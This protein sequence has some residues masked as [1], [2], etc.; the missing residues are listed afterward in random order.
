[1]FIPNEGSYILATNYKS[2]LS[3]EAFRMGVIILN[4]TN[5]M[6][7]LHLVLQTWHNSRQ[8]DNC[9]NIINAANNMYDKFVTFADNYNTLGNQLDT[10][11]RTYDKAMG[12]LQTGNANLLKQMDSLRNMGV[13]TTK[14][15]KTR[16]PKSLTQNAESVEIQELPIDTEA[17]D[18]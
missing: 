7:A 15:I 17:Q 16:E 3:M 11:K 13:N 2:S 1:M 18:L 6:L 14:R 12:Q 10:V 8:E 4:P 9:Q 5:L